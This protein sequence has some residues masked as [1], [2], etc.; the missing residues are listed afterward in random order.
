MKIYKLKHTLSSP[1]IFATP[2]NDIFVA[3]FLSKLPDVSADFEIPSFQMADP[4][5]S[6][7]GFFRID[8]SILAFTR[9]VFFGPLGQ[10]L[11]FAGHVHE[12]TLNDTGE[13]I[14]LLNVT[15]MYNCIDRAN[16]TFNGPQGPQR[17]VDHQMGIKEPAFFPNLIGDSSIFKIPQQARSTI[18]VASRGHEDT[19]DFY[20]MY[21]QLGMTGL[22]FQQVWDGD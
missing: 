4:A 1:N 10:S 3:E 9:N 13:E 7:S 2:R 8:N 16:T 15:A 18:Y 6:I 14:F 19:N 21:Q 5:K 22:E 17:G 20:Y 12:T 11:G